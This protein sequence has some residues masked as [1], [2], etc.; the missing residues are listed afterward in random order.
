MS[1]T[2]EQIALNALKQ[3]DELIN[4]AWSDE[5]RAAAAKARKSVQSTV[6][7]TV[8]APHARVQIGAGDY[9]KHKAGEGYITATTT[10]GYTVGMKK[11]RSDKDVRVGA[12]DITHVQLGS[13]GPIFPVKHYDEKND[14]HHLKTP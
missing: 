6:Q 11:R 9:V 12:S 1:K 14:M 3:F 10:Q 5:A 13:K 4:L 7:S 8:D 2:P